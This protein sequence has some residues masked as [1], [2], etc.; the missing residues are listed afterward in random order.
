[1]QTTYLQNLEKANKNVICTSSSPSTVDTRFLLKRKLRIPIFQRRYAWSEANWEQIWKDILA[2]ALGRRTGHFLGRMTCVL[3]DSAIVVIDGQQRSTTLFLLL[4][5]YRDTTNDALEAER[6]RDLLFDDDGQTRLVPTFC[7]RASF[8]RAV[9]SARK[10]STEEEEEEEG[11]PAYE[12]DRPIRAK[13]YFETRLRRLDFSMQRA[14]VDAVLFKLQWL[15]FPLDVG[16]DEK[17]DDGTD[18]LGII[19]ERLALREAMFTRPRNKNCYA[20]MAGV[21]FVRNL[22]L[23]GF[24]R[25]EKLALRMYETHW[26]VIECEANRVARKKGVN[27]ESLLEEML[28]SF[29][30]TKNAEIDHDADDDVID[31]SIAKPK[32]KYH[33][34]IQKLIGGDLYADFRE[35]VSSSLETSDSEEIL[36]LIKK[37]AMNIFFKGQ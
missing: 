19:F 37:F 8:L 29:L 35:Y 12:W 22:L 24:A 36:I 13:M 2:L 1:M 9:H 4:A 11:R 7:D 18:D 10:T 26:L 14:V 6:I 17:R 16:V 25:D 21:D 30:K 15:L 5:A 20:E 28:T 27:T 33:S 23:G 3:T 31:P 34:K 32:G